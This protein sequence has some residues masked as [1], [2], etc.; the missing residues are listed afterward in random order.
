MIKLRAE[1][2]TNRGSIDSTSMEF[3]PARSD[4]L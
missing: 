3:S 1:K 2:T 4:W